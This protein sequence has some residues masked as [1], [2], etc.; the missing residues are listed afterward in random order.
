MGMARQS[1][2]SGTAVPVLVTRPR[3]QGEDFARK[4]LARFG[5]RLRPIVAPLMATEFLSPPVPTG[6]FD[7]VI[8]T[9]A[10]GVEGAARLGAELPRRAYCVG[11][12]TAAAATKAG[13]DA[14]SSDGDVTDLAASLLAGPKT[15]RFLYLRGVDT[16]GE[17]ENTLI[18]HGIHALSLQVYL[19]EPIPLTGESLDL[20][21]QSG[22]VILP[23]FSPR[24][25]RIFHQAM[26]PD[27]RADLRIAVMSEAVARGAAPVPHSALVIAA[28][29]D[30]AAML[31]AVET[32]LAAGPLP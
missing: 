10:S 19:Q 2:P 32:L 22:P 21:R 24:S 15:G 31:D 3:A 5:S 4:L 30:A 26:P 23:L 9:S 18:S 13:F 11:R 12:A 1:D 8:F 14:L 28:R 7:A 17:L 6:P 16:A 25:A 29:P 20:L 27:T